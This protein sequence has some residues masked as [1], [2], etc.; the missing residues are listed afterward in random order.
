[1][2]SK[3][4][5][6]ASGD[7]QYANAPLPPIASGRVNGSMSVPIGKSTSYLPGGISGKLGIGVGVGEGVTVGVGVLVGVGVGV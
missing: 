7:S 3:L 2:L 5:P 1:M 6:G 4:R